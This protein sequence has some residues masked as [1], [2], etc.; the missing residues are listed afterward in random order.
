MFI[1]NLRIAIR[2]LAANK[3]RSVL[4]TLGIIIGVTSVIALVS[5]GNGVQQF[6]NSR[7]ES[8]GAN[9]VFVFPAR[10][11]QGGANRAGFRAFQ[12]GARSGI[13]L[14]L[15]QGDADA[16]RD[17]ER[18]PDA[19]IVAPVV[20]GQG[21]ISNGE[22]NYETRVRG[23]VAQYRE[24]NNAPVRYGRYLTDEDVQAGSR[25]VVLTDV[26]YRKLFPEG[27]DPTGADVRINGVPFRVVGVMAQRVGGAEGSDDD[28]LIVPITTARDRL[29]PQRN[30]RGEPLVGII[31]VQ[32]VSKDRID[33]LMQQIT[34]LLRERHNIQFAGEDDFSVA[35]QR[36]LLNTIGSITNAVT[37]FLAAIAGISLFVGGIGIMN[38]MLVSVTERT[39][40]IGL[41]KAIGARKSV[42]LQQFLI[43]STTLSL[44]GGMIGIVLG[45]SLAN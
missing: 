37:I 11:E 12:P 4:T 3:L 31:L 38:I 35:S 7:F 40:E 13:A 24:L 17:P 29:F 8:Q 32:A 15:T 23:T 33:P 6:I 1:E 41:R 16:L 44:L 42:I 34:D 10:V 25:V 2:A 14:S 5:L 19:K 18:V 36:D 9:L 39:R 22:R 30:A 20:S 26:P 27:G 45:V 43:E 21:R 28:V